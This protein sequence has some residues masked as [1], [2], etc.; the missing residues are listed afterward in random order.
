MKT[1]GI[2]FAIALAVAT[3]CTCN[4]HIV[5]ELR[6]PAYPLVTID[7]YVSTWSAADR[8]YD[9]APTHWTDR[10]KALTGIITV[11]G[12]DYRFMGN[13]ARVT[14]MVDG[15]AADNRWEAR[16]TFNDPGRNW[17]KADYDDSKW[18]SGRG[19]FGNADN[20]PNIGTDWK[21][22]TLWLRRTIMIDESEMEG[23]FCLRHR[24]REVATYYINGVEV[25]VSPKEENNEIMQELSPEACAL[26]HPGRNILAVKCVDNEKKRSLVECGIYRKVEIPAGCSNSAEQTLAD[27]QATQTHYEFNCGPVQLRLDFSAPLYDL[28][29]LELVSRPVNYIS[30]AVKSLD[31]AEHDVNVRII[32]SNQW[33]V[34]YPGMDCM[35]EEF[36]HAGMHFY[37]SGTKSQNVLGRKGDRICIDWGYFYFATPEDN[38]AEKGH[39]LIGYD[40]ICSV[41]YFGENLRP[42]WNRSGV[43]TILDEFEAAEKDYAKTMKACER[44]DREMFAEAEA[45]GGRK[46][47][48]LCALAY[49]QAIT[50]HK[51]VVLPNGDLDLF[52]KENNSNGSIGTVDVTYPSAPIF[53]KY[54]PLLSEALMNHIYDYSESGRWTKPFPAHDIGTYPLAN[55]QT[56]GADMP[57]EE[58]GN[59][60]ILTAATCAAKK[61]F[62]YAKK[63]WESLSA[64]VKYLQE[65][66][67]DPA[68]QLCTDDFAGHLSRNANLSI[69]AI[70]GIACYGYMA[71]RLGDKE[72]GEAFIAQAREAAQTWMKLAD[73]GDHYGLVFEDTKQSWSQK[74]NLVWDKLL[75]LGIFPEEVAQKET[76]YYL[77]RQN[78]YGLPLDSRR[79]YTKSDWIVWTATMAESQ[80]DFEALIAPE[81]NFYNE[82]TSRVPMSDWYNTDAPTFVSFI[83]RSVVG[84]YFIK[85]L[86]F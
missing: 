68:E 45:K 29:N 10:S 16:Y 23:T 52:S 15:N 21:G 20:R 85:M 79:N 71:D 66:G 70:M 2:L 61:D 49:R 46:Y 19:A 77:T 9:V 57:V 17:E 4:E 58:A 24:D 42:Y 3:S 73:Q 35:E 86:E 25:L 51:L 12:T 26:L 83:A 31:G 33:G 74:Y 53:L 81:W 7:P 28:R 54:N 14:Y 13:D 59:M 80:E 34:N 6:A 48:E 84:G 22:G 62:S 36:D 55:G 30:Y 37:K 56:Y 78:Q 8:L 64:W 27:V 47:A 76:A 65:D 18:A 41:Q 39:F 69:K 32:P 72:T 43:R 5:N 11:D 44:F 63:H 82:S 38:K 67:L 60:I 1:N 40:D 50:A 75:G